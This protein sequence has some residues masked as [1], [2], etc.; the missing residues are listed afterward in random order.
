MNTHSTLSQ[1][2]EIDETFKCSCCA[3]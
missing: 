1:T 3:V 2:R